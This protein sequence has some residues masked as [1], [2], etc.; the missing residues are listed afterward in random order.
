MID[1]C[2]LCGQPTL[3]EFLN[4]G[5]QPL[6]NKYPNQAQL[7]SEE[8]F[9]LAVYFCTHCKNVQLGTMVSRMQMFED[10][11]YLSSVNA[12]WCGILNS[13]QKNWHPHSL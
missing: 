11:Y 4:L 13:L 2:Q 7:A 10:Y 9:P 6:A 1:Q 5:R 8:F 3:R 12:G